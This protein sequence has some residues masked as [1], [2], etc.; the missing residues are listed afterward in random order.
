[1]PGPEPRRTAPGRHTLGSPPEAAEPLDQAEVPKLPELSPPDDLTD[2]AEPIHTIYGPPWYAARQR[3]HAGAGTAARHLV[4][5]LDVIE[6]GWHAL[7]DLQHWYECRVPPADTSDTYGHLL[8]FVGADLVDVFRVVAVSAAE[9]VPGWPGWAAEADP[10]GLLGEVDTFVRYLALLHW[11]VQAA[12]VP[13]PFAMLVV[14]VADRFTGWDSEVLALVT[15]V[16]P[17]ISPVDDGSP[18]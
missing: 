10:D 11:A 8:R 4:R 9:L 2:G 16:W 12:P 13:E 3:A 17:L 14:S 5:L 1:M 6:S 15:A 7:R 18:S